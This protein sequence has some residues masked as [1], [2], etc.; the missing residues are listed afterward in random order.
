MRLTK[1]TLGLVALLGVAAC[2][3]E[4]PVDLGG[5]LPGGGINTGEVVFDAPAFLEWDSV[6]TGFTNPAHADFVLAASEY[7]G[8]LDAHGLVRFQDLPR[9]VSYNDPDGILRVDTLPTL[10]GGQLTLRVD[11]LRTVGSGAISVGVYQVAEDWDLMSASWTSRV[12]TGSVRHPWTE[13]GGTRGTLI[14][15]A[16]YIPGDTI[17][18]FDV[19]SNMLSEL[20]DSANAA[21]GVL[22]QVES[23]GSRLEFGSATIQ[24]ETMPTFLPDTIMVDSVG[25]RAKTFVLN[26]TPEPET[27]GAILVGGLPSWR[28]YLRIK[29]DIDTLAVPCPGGPTGCT[30]RLR[31]VVINYAGLELQPIADYPGYA[32]LDTVAAESRAVLPVDGVPVARTPLGVQL[33]SP[34]N[35]PPSGGDGVIAVPITTLIMAMASDS[36]V[37]ASA[38]R[39]MALLG[40]PEGL[41][42]GLSAFGSL[43]AG[44]LAPR[45]RL[46]YSVTKEVQDR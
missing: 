39:T 34:V 33:G 45:L 41:H 18:T 37:K 23:P 38:P 11:T 24:F 1:M 14:G 4:D 29:E 25:I 12:D 40:S 9:T 7:G 13:P 44:P 10:L 36:A 46:I 31:D 3:E 8:H 15:A 20:R 6:R 19:D 2:G 26:P 5:L 27:D 35:I 43:S 16:E 32:P 28:T 42:F 17:L 30:Y 22:V 21:R